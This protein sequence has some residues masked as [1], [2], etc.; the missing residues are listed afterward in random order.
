MCL[1][2]TSFRPIL[3][4]DNFVRTILTYIIDE[5]H[6]ISQW[7][8]E[9]RQT[10]GLLDQLRA[11]VPTGVPVLATSATLNPK[12]FADVILSLKIYLNTAFYINLGNDRPNI[13]FSTLTI[14]SS[15]DLCSIKSFF[16]SD[17]DFVKD[18]RKTIIFTNDRQMSHDIC[19]YLR[20]YLPPHLNQTFAYYH[21]LLSSYTKKIIL[22]RFR[23]GE[24]KVLASTEVA[25]MV[26]NI[27]STLS[28]DLFVTNYRAP[29]FQTSN[30][31]YNLDSPA[32]LDH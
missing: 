6:C 3:T 15:S 12:A 29:I 27:S 23:A 4:S 19:R 32:F 28:F 13:S 5:A 25:G 30:T 22:E 31:L 20:S 8:G 21:A 2:D 17:L 9:F 1:L 7:G 10:Y 11:F 26:R 16:P 24:I 18:I 14:N